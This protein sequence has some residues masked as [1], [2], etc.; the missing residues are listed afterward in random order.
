M[1]LKTLQLERYG[2][3]ANHALHFKSKAHGQPDLHIIYGDNEAGKTTALSAWL[4]FLFGIKRNTPY[5]F[6]HGRSMRVGACLEDDRAAITLFRHRG[7]KDTLKRDDGTTESDNRLTSLL[8]GLGR[9]Q[10]ELIYSVNDETLEKGG[11]EIVNS[12]G[13]LGKLLFSASAGIVEVS[14]RLESLERDCDAFYRVK[15]RKTKLNEIKA[16]LKELARQKTTIEVT[17]DEYARIAGTVRTAAAELDEA[18]HRRDESLRELHDVENRLKALSTVKQLAT[19][20]RQQL[21]IGTL[22][23]PPPNWREMWEETK[24]THQQA[25]ATK[26]RLEVEVEALAGELEGLT[27]DEDALALG[28]DIEPLEARQAAYVSTESDLPKRVTECKVHEQEIKLRLKRIG[29]SDQNAENGLADATLLSGLRDLINQSAGIRGSVATCKDEHDRARERFEDISA[30]LD[31]RTIGSNQL[32]R[33][34]SCLDRMGHRD[35]RLEQ[36]AEDKNLRSIDSRITEFLTKLAPWSGTIRDLAQLTV[37]PSS[38]IAVWQQ[39]LV[40]LRS[41]LDETVKGIADTSAALTQ[42]EA[43]LSGSATSRPVSYQDLADL[44]QRRE[45]AWGDHR[46]ALDARTAATFETALREHDELIYRYVSDQTRAVERDERHR[47]RDEIKAALETLRARHVDL[48]GKTEAIEK[49]VLSELGS[50]LPGLAARE[51]IKAIPDW[52]ATRERAMEAWHESLRLRKRAVVLEKEITALRD[53][54]GVA[55]QGAQLA[56]PD[57]MPLDAMITLARKVLLETTRNAEIL[58]RVGQAERDLARRSAA[59]ANAVQSKEAW[60]AQWRSACQAVV[61]GQDDPTVEVMTERLEIVQEIASLAQRKQALDHR[62]RAMR[63]DREHFESDIR[64]IAATLG[65]EVANPLEAWRAISKA[66]RTARDHARDRKRVQDALIKRQKGLQE[67]ADQLEETGEVIAALGEVYNLTEIREIEQ[68]LDQAERLQQLTEAARELSSSLGD[69]LSTDDADTA[70][71]ELQGVVRSDLEA[72]KSALAQEC[73]TLGAICNEKLTEH[74]RCRHALETISGDDDVARLES[75]IA[76]LELGLE[77]AAVDHLRQ[78]L[79][80]LAL[81]AVIRKYM[82]THRSGMMEKASEVFHL[83]TG[84]AYTSLATE[85]QDAAEVLTV[86]GADGTAKLAD[87]LSKGTRFQLYLA[88]RIAGIHETLK[89]SPALPFIADDVL[90][91]FDDQ[92]AARTLKALENLACTT[93]VI[94]FTHHRHLC[95]IA[96]ETCPHAS[97]QEIRIS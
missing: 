33:I 58:E 69:I 11:E 42:F 27:V 8:G 87:G 86:E 88:L 21:E 77:E 40:Q 91:T 29:V 97:I 18:Q 70:E 14:N 83:I 5:G 48:L 46:D 35:P 26:K 34:E 45:E 94:Y 31:K 63:S 50:L 6:R 85:F 96:R 90:E 82:Q 80:I 89:S 52:L 7:T 2:L 57:N 84:G 75:R 43:A 72:R 93:Q 22:P 64:K 16:E 32:A 67:M 30:R 3:F 36:R 65:I 68:A 12:R 92:R 24:A 39:S 71:R 59:A 51:A 73:E 37:P 95:T 49:S 74:D 13:D 47:K 79:G 4:D 61:F 9:T 28:D 78:R 60:Q 25:Q 10:Y 20:R 38:R 17:A 19:N 54:F 55:L 15:G 53:D 44:R 1:R 62:M 56:I 41:K 81:E 23:P 76:N 66:I